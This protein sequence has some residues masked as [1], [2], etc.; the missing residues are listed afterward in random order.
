MSNLEYWESAVGEALCEHTE[1]YS[2]FTNEQLSSIA[3]DL[4]LAAEME[5]EYSGVH[6][7][8]NPQ[9]AEIE[10]L[11]RELKKESSK[12]SCP[13]CNGSGRTQH[14]VGSFHWADTQC[15]RCN[16]E[17]KITR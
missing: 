9:L 2:Q 8:P 4:M 14:K 12:V 5:G 11:K 7:I 3:K 15:Y 17:A 16:G 10:R 13:V 1:L 6:S